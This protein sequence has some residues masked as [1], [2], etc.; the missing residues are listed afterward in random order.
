MTNKPNI[1]LILVDDMGYSDIGCY[2]GEIDTPNLDTLGHRGFRFTQF[3]NTAKCSPSRASLLTGLHPHQVGMGVLAYSGMQNVPEPPDGYVGNLS[4]DCV[5]IPEVLKEAGYKT[6]LSGKWHLSNDVNNEDDTW[7]RARGFDHHYGNISGATSYFYPCKMWRDGVNVEDEALNDPDFYYTDA[8]SDQACKYIEQHVE[9]DGEKPFFMYV[10]YTCPH[11]PLHAKE[12]DLEKYRGHYAEGWDELRKNRLERLRSMGVLNKSWQLSPSD[13]YF[14][15]DDLEDDEKRWFESRME[16]Y[17]AMIDCM[18]QG[19]GRI[20]SKLKEK[21][22]FDDTL[23]IFL[24]DN[25]A[26]AEEI[27]DQSKKWVG[28]G[29]FRAKT[30]DGRPIQFGCNDDIKPGGEETHQS[31]GRQWANLSNTPFRLYK[32]SIH[33]GG[34]STPLIFHWPNGSVPRA[35]VSHEPTQLM[36]I[37]PTICEIAGA[38]YPEE[39]KGN[40]IQPCEGKSLVPCFSDKKP[41]KE[42]LWWE[43]QDSGGVR[44]KNWKLVR[45]RTGPWEL[46][47][48]YD[49]RTELKDV[50]KDHED[51]VSAMS[52][53]WK[54]IA[55]K[56]KVLPTGEIAMIKAKYRENK[57]K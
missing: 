28:T 52:S 24:S 12:N 20:V 17:A 22:I 46:Y 25:G 6:Y 23:V 1:I 48:M 40:K 16:A 45:F 44:E 4:K 36:D 50:S 11:W 51:K 15:W 55:D 54:E 2:G 9:N 47:D 27:G 32:S 33:E 37:M 26:S 34:I 29:V 21:N 31:Y 42:R 13:A 39:Y 14:T 57:L 30:R 7:P 56:V 49:D 8:I 43:H 18:D 35:G 5:L 19:V 41:G 53:K 3:Y 10:A 38:T